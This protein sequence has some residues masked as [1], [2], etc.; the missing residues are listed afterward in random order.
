MRK[1]GNL[2]AHLPVEEVER[3]FRTCRDA[4]VK[5]RWQAIWLRMQGRATIE[6][7]GIISCKPGTYPEIISEPQLVFHSKI[8]RWFCYG[9]Q[10]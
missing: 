5:S 10:V 1:H 4:R 8:A 6:V 3:R 7:A 2:V 9:R